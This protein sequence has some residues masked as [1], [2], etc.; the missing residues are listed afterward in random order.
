ML[1]FRPDYCSIRGLILLGASTQEEAIV[2]TF[3]LWLI[4]W[5]KP[6]LLIIAQIDAC[7]SR[8]FP[9][10]T[11]TGL[12][13]VWVVLANLAD[14]AIVTLEVAHTVFLILAIFAS[15]IRQKV[16]AIP[17]TGHRVSIHLT[18]QNVAVA[19]ADIR[20]SEGPRLG[21]SWTLLLAGL[22]GIGA[23]TCESA[24]SATASYLYCAYLSDSHIGT[25]PD[26][27]EIVV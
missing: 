6:I 7:T 18:I 23:A 4:L 14:T 27:E 19:T 2:R 3:L 15:G 17:S 12:R 11:L 21:R 20:S 25:S 16:S 5:W 13:L 8:Y 9:A 26:P 22:A 24:R 1:R 10:P